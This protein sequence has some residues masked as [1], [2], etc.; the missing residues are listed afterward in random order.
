MYFGFVTFSLDMQWS[1]V[2]PQTNLFLWLIS[3]PLAIK[4]SRNSRL[5]AWIGKVWIH[6]LDI[7]IHE[8]PLSKAQ[9]NIIFPLS[10][11]SRLKP[12]WIS[13]FNIFICTGLA[14]LQAR[15]LLSPVWEWLASLGLNPSASR[16]W[17]TSVELPFRWKRVYQWNSWSFLDG[18]SETTLNRFS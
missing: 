12:Y 16:C 1:H 5:S 6:S 17:S 13:N 4:A 2:A 10:W 14:C 3:N 7:V 8:L 15:W 18:H 9:L 11:D